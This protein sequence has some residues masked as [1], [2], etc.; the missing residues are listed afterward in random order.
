MSSWLARM[1][2]SEIGRYL[3]LSLSLSFSLARSLCLTL[4][5][6]SLSFGSNVGACEPAAAS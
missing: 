4:H 3:F 1:E 5:F 2:V 6:H